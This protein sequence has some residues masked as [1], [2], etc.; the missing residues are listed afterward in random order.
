M[1]F[2]SLSR[3]FPGLSPEHPFPWGTPL[4]GGTPGKVLPAPESTK[5]I[6]S[7]IL[8]KWSYQFK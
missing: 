6:T 2:P 8:L 4:E 1:F 3:T 7:V 5:N